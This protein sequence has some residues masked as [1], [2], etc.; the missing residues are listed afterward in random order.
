M[1]V[2]KFFW[3][4]KLFQPKIERKICMQDSLKVSYDNNVVHMSI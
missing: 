1:Q 3:I 4:R 2:L